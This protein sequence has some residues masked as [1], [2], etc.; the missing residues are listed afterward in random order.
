[1]AK[2]ILVE[3]RLVRRCFRLKVIE[4]VVRFTRGA[5]GC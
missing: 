2:T 4:S 1:M 3:G 5:E